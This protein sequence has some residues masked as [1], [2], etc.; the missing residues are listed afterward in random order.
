MIIENSK[1]LIQLFYENYPGRV[2]AWLKILFNLDMTTSY[3]KIPGLNRRARRR[4]ARDG[5]CLISPRPEVK[6]SRQVDFK[7]KNELHG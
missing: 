4:T 1:I 5:I 6:T 2:A 7:R 3:I